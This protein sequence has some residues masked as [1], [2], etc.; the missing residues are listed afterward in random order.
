MTN[1]LGGNGFQVLDQGHGYWL[2][3]NGGDGPSVRYDHRSTV[4]RGDSIVYYGGTFRSVDDAPDMW[5]MNATMLPSSSLVKA[6]P[7]GMVSDRHTYATLSDHY[8]K[9]LLRVC[10][11]SDVL[12]RSLG[13]PLPRPDHYLYG[14]VLLYIEEE[15]GHTSPATS[16]RN[17]HRRT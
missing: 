8:L 10:R 5:I 11:A 7:E 6:D 1:R 13:V 15:D 4:W 9:A 12:L 2:K 16:T 17:C 14:R 3:Y